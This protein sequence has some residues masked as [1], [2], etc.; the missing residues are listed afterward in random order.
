MQLKNA[1]FRIGRFFKQTLKETGLFFRF[2]ITKTFLIH[3]S[4]AIALLIAIFIGISVFLKSY[5]QHGE[6]F[7]VPDFRGLKMQEVKELAREKKLAY[8]VIDSVYNFTGRK[9]TVVEQ[10]PPPG[11]KVKEGRT[12]FITRQKYR[13]ARVEVPSFVEI[14][15]SQARADVRSRGLHVERVKYKK[16]EYDDLVLE[17]Y[18]NGKKL[19]PGTKIPKGSGITLVVSVESTNQKTVVPSFIGL[20]SK[21]A[22]SRAIDFKLNLG[23]KHYDYTVK[24]R[25]DT[26]NARVW[27]QNPKPESGKVRIG[28]PVEVYLTLSESKLDVGKLADEMG[29]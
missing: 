20:T 15:P 22:N 28:S 25:L 3:F 12:I 2:L 26:V 23:R 18:Y 1:F 21:V 29:N 17:Q 19:E 27:Q 8:E 5:T 6:S 9:G 7:A 16:W 13:R 11:F 10:T 24:T 4:I 14:S